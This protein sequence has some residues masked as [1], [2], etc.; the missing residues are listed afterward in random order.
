MNFQEMVTEFHRAINHPV[1]EEPHML[2]ERHLSDRVEWIKEETR[3]LEDADNLVDQVDA[4]TD[5]A[6]F[7]IGFFVE[8]GIDFETMFRIVHEANMRKVAKE[9]RYRNDGKIEKPVN[10]LPPE[11][12]IAME[13]DRVKDEIKR[14]KDIDDMDELL[15][16][17]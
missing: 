6:Y 17:L 1:N 10:W 13:I 16:K 14:R 12:E 5:L 7:I 9:V 2:D 3:E 8:M 4:L 11:S 15:E